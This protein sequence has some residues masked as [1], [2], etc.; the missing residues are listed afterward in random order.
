MWDAF[1]HHHIQTRRHQL[2][3]A[4]SPRFHHTLSPTDHHPCVLRCHVP[5]PHHNNSIIRNSGFG[6]RP[7]GPASL[8]PLQQQLQA[9][10]RTTAATLPGFL[11]RL[12]STLNWT[13]TEFT[14]SLSDLAAQRGGGSRL[15]MDAQQKYRRT[16]LMFEMSCNLLR[17]LEFV[18]VQVRCTERRRGGGQALLCCLASVWLGA[19]YGGA[20]VMLV[21]M[22]APW[23]EMHAVG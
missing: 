20:W 6:Q 12:F 23:R 15:A 5:S 21:F 8:T 10:C 7:A 4:L 19:G 9:Q 22:W 11:H 1:Y 14:S 16:I 18:V 3:L 13:L 2:T 17:V